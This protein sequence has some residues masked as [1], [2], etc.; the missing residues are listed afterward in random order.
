MITFSLGDSRIVEHYEIARFLQ[1]KGFT[2]EEIQAMY[3]RQIEKDAKD[4]DKNA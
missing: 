3:N 4:G 1:T 2:D